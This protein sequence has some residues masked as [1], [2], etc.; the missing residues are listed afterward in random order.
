MA[1]QQV[2][3]RGQRALAEPGALA[4]SARNTCCPLPRESLGL[5]FHAPWAPVSVGQVSSAPVL[6]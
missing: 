5:I 2:P 6:C 3:L 4:V 1:G